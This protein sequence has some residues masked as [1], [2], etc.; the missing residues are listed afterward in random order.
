MGGEG[1]DEIDGN[2]GADT[3]DGGDDADLLNG[4]NGDDSLMGGDGDD[5]LDGGKGDNDLVGGDGIDTARFIVED[6][7]YTSACR[8]VPSA[9]IWASPAP[10]PRLKTSPQAMAATRLRAIPAIIR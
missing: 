7:A 10:S 6:N 3:L 5:T 9:A 8:T 1:S 4:G 2:G